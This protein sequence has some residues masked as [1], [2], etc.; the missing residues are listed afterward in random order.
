M[1]NLID[2]KIISAASKTAKIFA[3]YLV[4]PVSAKYAT[5]SAFMS[6]TWAAYQSIASS[7]HS[8]VLNGKVF[9]ALVATALLKAG[10]RPL[11]AEANI[12]F[13]PNVRFDLV[14]YSQNHGP[15]VLSLKTSLRERYKQADLEGMFLRNVHRKALSYLITTDADECNNVN[16][17][18]KT[19][20]VLGID[21]CVLATDPAFD[22]LVKELVSIKLIDP[23]VVPVLKSSRI[24]K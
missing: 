21:K 2:A 18:I 8:K 17:K 20:D 13:I 7:K 15:V 24:I 19:G 9:E 4:R 6:A 22:A 14:L 10:V 3:D 12:T 1:R 11:F 5:S 16:N 23:P